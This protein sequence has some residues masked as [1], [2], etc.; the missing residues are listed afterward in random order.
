MKL[1][2]PLAGPVVAA[3]VILPARHGIQ[4]LKDSKMLSAAQRERL[5]CS[6]YGKAAFG[7]GIA[8]HT[9]I[10]TK[11]LIAATNLAFQR[12]IDELPLCQI[13]FLKMDAIILY[14]QCH[15]CSIIERRSEI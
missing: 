10:D 5:F 9:E 12:A 2:R 4:G 13:C 15:F 3:V 1:V 6:N 7:I 11:A 14:C 8:S